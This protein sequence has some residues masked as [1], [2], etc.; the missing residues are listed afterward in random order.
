MSDEDDG[1]R[2]WFLEKLRNKACYISFEKKNGDLRQMWC[3]LYGEDV[4]DDNVVIKY[5]GSPNQIVWDMRLK[6]YRSFCWDRLI[7]YNFG[8]RLPESFKVE[9]E[10]DD[11]VNYYS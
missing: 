4:Q 10:E 7:S 11:F 3:Q 6:E 9:D 1:F 5:E 8:G 2:Q